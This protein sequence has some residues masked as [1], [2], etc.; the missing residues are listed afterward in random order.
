[1]KERIENCVLLW[2]TQLILKNCFSL[3]MSFLSLLLG[4]TLQIR[5]KIKQSTATTSIYIYYII[6]PPGVI[7]TFFNKDISNG[8]V[9]SLHTLRINYE[10]IDII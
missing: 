5:R 4:Q 3:L 10:D 9:M 7:H 8:K 1:M 2:R 6:L